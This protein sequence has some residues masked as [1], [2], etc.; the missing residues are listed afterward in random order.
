[1]RIIKAFWYSIAGFKSCFK[2]EAAFREEVAASIVLIPLAIYLAKSTTDLV[3][4]I[5]PIFIMLIVEMLNTSIEYV[6][7]RIGL[8]HNALSGGAKDIAS[9]A[10]FLSVILLIFTWIVVLWV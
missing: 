4:L 2:T 10:V 7:D 3:L 5:L 6:V 9:A 1:M 8:E